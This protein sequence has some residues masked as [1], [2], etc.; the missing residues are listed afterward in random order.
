MLALIPRSVFRLEITT[1]VGEWGS[2]ERGAGS[3]ERGAGSGER[4]AGSGERGAGSGERGAG[5]RGAGERG[6][7]E[8]MSIAKCP[9]YFDRDC[10]NSFVVFVS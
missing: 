3:G 7:G 5:E 4:G 9:N 1:L 2:G 10:L 6:T 8:G